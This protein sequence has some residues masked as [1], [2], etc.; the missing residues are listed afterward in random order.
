VTSACPCGCGRKVGFVE[1][2]LAKRAVYISSLMIVPERMRDQAD[3]TD[4]WTSFLRLGERYRDSYLEVAHGAPNDLRDSAAAFAAFRTAADVWESRALSLARRLRVE[5]QEW[6]A[7]W[8]GPSYRICA[9]PSSAN[10]PTDAPTRE[11]ATE[12]N[13]SDDSRLRRSRPTPNGAPPVNS[14]TRARA[15]EPVP[16]RH[17]S[18]A[19]APPAQRPESA[20]AARQCIFCTRPAHSAEFLWSEWL[21]RPFVDRMANSRSESGTASC[22]EQLRRE[23]D[24]TVDSVCYSCTHGWIQRLDDD[25][26]AF[27]PPMIAGHPTRLSP[28]QQ[29]LLAQ[30]GAKTAALG[31]CL[32]RTPPQELRVAYSGLPNGD[33]HPGSQVLVGAYTG[34]SRLLTRDRDVFRRTVNGAER[35]LPQSTFIIG[36][37]FIQVFADPWLNSAP[38]ACVDMSQLLIALVPRRRRRVQWP[39]AVPIDDALYDLVRRGEL[40]D[41]D[42]TGR[43]ARS[44]T[45]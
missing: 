33:L 14:P 1:R 43:A 3:R 16:V 34:D 18:V 42:G 5:D 21:C 37:L 2:C 20:P 31:E 8:P 10:E 24:Q 6:Y 30:W 32:Y 15:W 13:D 40:T 44:I 29:H 27:L 26:I 39:P 25:V 23:V 11:P 4:E 19:S 22:V 28:R 38:E 9:T 7:T 36:K 41:D 12:P 45:A 17:R 35:Q